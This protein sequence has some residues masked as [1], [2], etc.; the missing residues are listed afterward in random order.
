[1][2]IELLRTFLEVDRQHH[3]GRAAERLFLT[4]SAVSARIRQLEAHM[5][6]ALFLRER[7]GIRLTEA[8][9]RLLPHAHRLLA[10]WQ[11]ATQ[12]VQSTVGGRRSFRFVALPAFWSLRV[13]RRLADLP[14][15]FPALSFRFESRAVDATLA[16]LRDG[17]IDL[18]LVSGSVAGSGIRSHPLAVVELRCYQSG[19]QDTGADVEVDI[20]WGPGIT[21]ERNAVSGAPVVDRPDFAL[22]ILESRAGRIWLPPELT[23]AG[24]EPVDIE[25]RKLELILAWCDSGERGALAETVCNWLAGEH[26]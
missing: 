9:E 2:D 21:L 25:P 8:G 5:G 10:E 16:G 22:R 20:D 14:D 4:Q 26:A 1:M 23:T 6:V 17:G 11:D 19:G 3:F 13:A 7:N 12:A 24:L 18:A 15:A